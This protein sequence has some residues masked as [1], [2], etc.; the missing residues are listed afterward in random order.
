[1]DASDANPTVDADQTVRMRDGQIVSL[2]VLRRLWAIEARGASFVMVDGG[3]DV[4]PN[5]T[6]TATDRAFI[7]RT[8]D[9]AIRIVHLQVVGDAP[10]ARAPV[11]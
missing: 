3:F 2:E 9:E 11:E 5:S 4:E 8:L 6:L 1:M 10:P 7:L